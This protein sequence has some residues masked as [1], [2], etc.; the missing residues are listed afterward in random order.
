[1][2]SKT[3]KKKEHS[4]YLIWI[5]GVSGSGKSTLAK[6][7]I[8][9]LRKMI[10]PTVL[11]NGDDLRK[12]FNLDSYEYHKR[13]KIA[14][15]YSRLCDFIIQQRINVVFATVSLFDDVRHL[16]RKKIKNNYIEI[17]INSPIKKILDNKKKKL[18]FSK[19]KLV[20]RDIKAEYP[21]NPDILI[22][23]NFKVS[24]NEISKSI[25]LKIKKNLKK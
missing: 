5:T 1:M 14:Y 8:K 23:N 12:M 2:K 16:N 24:L 3:N 9:P 6:K 25:L 4:A 13:N 17:F 21:K 18:Y 19:K 11:F 10:G 22:D 7:I 15:S 20:G